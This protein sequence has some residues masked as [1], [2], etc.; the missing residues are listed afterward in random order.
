MDDYDQQMIQRAVAEQIDRRAKDQ[1]DA[2]GYLT[3]FAEEK[4]RPTVDPFKALHA[5]VK[6]AVTAT[7]GRGDYI[8]RKLP[9]RSP[10]GGLRLPSPIRPAPRATVI[11]DT[12]GTHAEVAFQ[13]KPCTSSEQAALPSLLRHLT[14]EMLLIWDRNFFSYKLWKTLNSREIKVLARI[15]ANLILEPIERLSDGSY[16]AKIYPTPYAR[17]KDRNGIV[18]RVIKYTLDD[19]GLQAPAS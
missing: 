17:Q 3:R 2:P 11:V 10:P 7:T 15:K 8:W 9:R 13:I 12:S 5:A 1:G 16:L 4:L 14:P 18:V 6:Y 19:P